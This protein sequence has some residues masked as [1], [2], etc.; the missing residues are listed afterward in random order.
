MTNA[1]I[2]ADQTHGLLNR[3][4]WPEF[5]RAPHCGAESRDAQGYEWFCTLSQGH[6]Y[7]PVGHPDRSR[8]HVG[9]YTDENGDDVP[10]LVWTS[11]KR[12]WD[13]P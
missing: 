11:E 6:E 3:S 2:I 8:H 13:A 4:R 12:G 7:A 10:G 9:H 1:T 5:G